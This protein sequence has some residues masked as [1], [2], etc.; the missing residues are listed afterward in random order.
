MENITMIKNCRECGKTFSIT[1]GQQERFTA[2][3]L[4]LPTRCPRCREKRRQVEYAKCLDCG[5]MFGIDA[6][7]KEWYRKHGWDLPKRCIKCRKK[8][9]EAGK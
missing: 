3:K 4:Q 1:P 2:N 6:L 5:E 8:R 9:R 7:Q